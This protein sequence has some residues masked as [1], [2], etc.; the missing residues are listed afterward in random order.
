MATLTVFGFLAIVA[1][2]MYGPDVVKFAR[3]APAPRRAR[4]VRVGCASPRTSLSRFELVAQGM[5]EQARA[6]WEAGAPRKWR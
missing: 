5:A 6:G 2:W 3:R 4:G 1:A